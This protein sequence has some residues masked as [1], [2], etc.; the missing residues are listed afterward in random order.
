VLGSEPSAEGGSLK[1]WVR[2][3]PLGRWAI[4][5]K[6]KKF[7]RSKVQKV[8]LEIDHRENGRRVGRWAARDE[9]GRDVWQ[10]VN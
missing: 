8:H 2:V 6:K 5:K 4:K 7:N 9:S 10:C 1:A 3:S